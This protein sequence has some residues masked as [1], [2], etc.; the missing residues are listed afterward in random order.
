MLED[1]LN[2]CLY[3]NSG[4][5]THKFPDYNFG[6]GRTIAPYETLSVRWVMDRSHYL[7]LMGNGYITQVNIRNNRQRRIVAD[8]AQQMKVLQTATVFYTDRTGV[9]W[10]GS[11]GYGLLKYDPATAGFHHV[12]P[13]AN[14]YQLLEDKKGNIVTNNLN[15]LLITEDSVR[16]L[17]HFVDSSVKGQNNILSFA[18]DTAGRLWFGRNGA[19]LRYDPASKTVE[20]FAVP[21]TEYATLPFPLLADKAT[22]IWM[23][24]GRYLVKYDWAANKFSRYEHPVRFVQYNYDFLQSMYEDEDLL[25]LG[26]INGLI[27]F[28]TKEEMMLR[29]YVNNEQ[30]STTIASNVAFSFCPD[31][32]EPER[33]L[34]IGTKG[35]GL[36]KLDKATG[37][38]IHFNTRQGLSNNVVY[39]I[40]PDYGGNLWLSTNKGLSAFNMAS[41][42]FRNFDVSDG[43]QS[44]EFNRYAYMRTSEGIMVFGGLNGI[45]YFRSD[46]IRP[47]DPPRVVLTDFRLFNRSVEPGK[48]SLLTKAIDATKR[49]GLSYDENVITFQFAAMDY[50]KK[51]SIRYRYRMTGFDRGWIYSG[52]VHEAT[53]TN[54]DPGTYQFSV[55]ASFENGEWSSGGASV[56]L[57]IATP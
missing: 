5:A 29:V 16:N 28:D 23:G 39:G 46:E 19:L 47:L 30:N 56:E 13:G 52:G 3:L 17:A 40:L 57:Y 31:V 35:G 12:L 51:G 36:N 11:G 21:F 42:S 9:V 4:N 7:W 24:Y 18:R 33:Y 15:A 43:L 27:C 14:V 20:R 26:S 41:R 53:C 54:L 45:N 50:R 48:D 25:W 38:F 49:I 1:T 55:Q 32:E 22:N 44:N 2:H 34:W 8:D 37:R 6:N 10:L